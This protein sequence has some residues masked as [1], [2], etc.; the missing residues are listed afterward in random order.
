[1]DFNIVGT[2]AFQGLSN[3]VAHATIVAFD[4][5]KG[6]EP[7]TLFPPLLFMAGT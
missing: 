2:I 4:T 7:S 1:M 6:K 5:N 3:Q